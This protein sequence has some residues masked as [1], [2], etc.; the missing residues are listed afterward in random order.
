MPPG[1]VCYSQIQA[2]LDKKDKKSFASFNL[3]GIISPFL[4]L[5]GCHKQKLLIPSVNSQFYDF[6]GAEEG[7]KIS[8]NI[9]P[10]PLRKQRN[11][12]VPERDSTCS[13]GY[14]QGLYLNINLTSGSSSRTATLRAGPALYVRGLFCF[15]ALNIGYNFSS[16][17][18]RNKQALVWVTRRERQ[19]GGWLCSLVRGSGWI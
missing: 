6:I 15:T 1:L 11:Q 17:Q 9:F 12:D 10:P 14:I 13:W 16:Q 18:I 8:E 7:L 3:S 2:R 5:Q 19:H 4:S